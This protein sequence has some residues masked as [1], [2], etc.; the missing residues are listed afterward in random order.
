MKKLTHKYLPLFLV[1]LCSSAL[2]A[3]QPLSLQQCRQLAL[4]HNE[5]LKHA[6]N[7]LMQAE[8]DKQIAFASYLP[9]LD[10]SLMGVYGKDIDMMG[11]ST[12][13]MH[14]MWM[15]GLTL[16]QPLYV[17]GQITTGNKLAAVGLKAKQELLRKTRAEVIKE[18]DNSY[19][20]LI[21]V[22]EK[23]K[24]LQAY[25][26][27]MNALYDQVQLSV[28][29]E[30]ATENDLLRIATKQS[31]IK[32]QL[33]KAQNGVELCRMALCST[34]GLELTDQLQL[35]DT[36]I[37]AQAPVN[38]DED[39]SA[40]PEVALLQQQ[41]EVS[42]YQVKMAQ[43]NY[44]P[45]VAL[46]LG[47]NHMDNMK[48]KGMAQGSD[49]NYY[50]YTKDYHNN[51]TT[52]LLSVQVPLFHWGSELKKVKKARLDVRNA[53]LDMEKNTRLLGIEARQAVQNL[54]SGYQMIETSRLGRDQADQNLANMQLKYDNEMCTLTDLLDAESQWQQARS[55][56]IEALTQYKIYETEYLRVTGRLD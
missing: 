29:A 38:L 34:L 44:L 11:M 37:T 43:S 33:Q 23:V 20:T 52:A 27:Q 15:A 22:Q 4:Q 48:L 5:D 7:A 51:S 30:M 50:P 55:N 46:S 40:R 24:M 13:Q 53:Q 47:Y 41:L 17:G 49:G 32:Y 14:G 18:V 36:E 16:T 1:V 45:T 9:Q 35:I 25:E 54:T 39:I 10:G 3:Q 26:R 2:S 28:D 21:A 8:I 56:E 19:W 6:D 31:E 12:I 42:K